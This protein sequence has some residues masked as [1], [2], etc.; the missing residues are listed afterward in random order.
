MQDKNEN[1]V[2]IIICCYNSEKVIEKSLTSILNQKSSIPYE[3]IIVDNNCSDNTISMVNKIYKES[4]VTIPMRVIKESVPGVGYARKRGFAETKYTYISFIDDDNIIANDWID[5]VYDLFKKNPEI[6][7][8]GSSNKALFLDSVE[9]EWFDKV[10]GAYACD[11]QGAD[12]QELTVSR[13]Y[14]YGAGMSIRRE[15]LEAVY[16]IDL[17]LYL[18]GRK[19]GKLLSGDDSEL[20]M[21]AILLGYRMYCS[22]RLKL[23]HIML[24]ERLNW[25]YFQK[26]SEGHSQ[27]SIILQIY[28]RLIQGSRPLT[29]QEIIKELIIGWRNYIQTYK[30]RHLDQPNHISSQ[31]YIALKGRTVGIISFFSRYNEIV[32]K[33]IDALKVLD[34]S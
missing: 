19:G 17:P 15:V 32:Q 2:S 18:S 30:F 4:C 6:G 1:G 22:D 21:R 9:P 34:S 7:I 27:S 13:K 20:G 8:F 29:R 25:S 23:K 10:K 33:I 16:A 11:S 26:M 5:I 24:E 12:L 14:V 3:L 28:S 31:K